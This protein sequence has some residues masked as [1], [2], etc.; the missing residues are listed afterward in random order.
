MC[1]T[2]TAKRRFVRAR[3]RLRDNPTGSLKVFVMN[4]EDNSCTSAGPTRTVILAL[5]TERNNDPEQLYM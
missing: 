4:I 1:F 2:H 3:E 5:D